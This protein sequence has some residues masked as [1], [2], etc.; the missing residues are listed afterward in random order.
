ML[1]IKT[2]RRKVGRPDL[3]RP[4]LTSRRLDKQIHK[5]QDRLTKLC[6]SKKGQE[7]IVELLQSEYLTTDC[8]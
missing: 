3:S 2:I 5:D 1:N 8:H 7:R 4:N 6:A